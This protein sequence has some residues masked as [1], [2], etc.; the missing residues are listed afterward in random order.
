MTKTQIRF[1]ITLNG[2]EKLRETLS[3]EFDII[4]PN[5]SDVLSAVPPVSISDL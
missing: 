3:S 5:G 2:F 4:E 1:T